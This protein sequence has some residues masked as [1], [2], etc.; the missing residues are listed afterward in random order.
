MSDHANASP[1]TRVP[2]PLAFVGAFLIGLLLQRIAWP[3]AGRPPAQL[4]VLGRALVVLGVASG[5]SAIALFLA[6]RTT[7]VP[8]GQPARFVVRGPYRFT[9]NPMYVGLLVAYAGACAWTGT[10][11]ALPFIVLPVLLLSRWVI[12]MEEAG[13]RSRFGGEY[14]DYCL[15]V[16]RWL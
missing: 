2:P 4:V 11:L 5:L 14:A 10:W 12:P 8:H 3:H 6:H 13:L 15:R 1:V 9:R 7:V 16:R